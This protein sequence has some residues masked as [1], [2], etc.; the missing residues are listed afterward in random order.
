VEDYYNNL[1]G[2]SLLRRALQKL[3][4]YLLMKRSLAMLAEQRR[5][6][7]E[8]KRRAEEK[9]KATEKRMAEIAAKR[10]NLEVKPIYQGVMPPNED[11]IQEGTEQSGRRIRQ[12]R[13]GSE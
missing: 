4:D 11:G 8:A 10:Q 3:K 9:R 1:S 6:T 12:G 13:G 2:T 5:R 7:D